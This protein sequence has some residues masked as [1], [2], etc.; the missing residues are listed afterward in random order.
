[1]VSSF[2]IF[3]VVSH[4][5]LGLMGSEISLDYMRH[6]ENWDCIIL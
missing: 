6:S 1:M 5:F 4:H 3:V 2:I